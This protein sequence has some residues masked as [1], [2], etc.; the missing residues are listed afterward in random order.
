[1]FKSNASFD[2]NGLLHQ[3]HKTS[4]SIGKFL[5]VPALARGVNHV[6]DRLGRDKAQ[7]SG[8]SS[9][10]ASSQVWSAVLDANDINQK[11]LVRQIGCV[12]AH[13]KASGAPNGDREGLVIEGVLKG[14]FFNVL[15]KAAHDGAARPKTNVKG[16]AAS[17]P[18]AGKDLHEA[19]VG[20]LEGVHEWLPGS[21]TAEGSAAEKDTGLKLFGHVDAAVEGSLLDSVVCT[22]AKED[23]NGIA[24]SRGESKG[25]RVRRVAE[26][27]VGNDAGSLPPKA[28]R[29][30]LADGDF[31]G[32]D[33]AI[34]DGV[35]LGSRLGF[36]DRSR[37]AGVSLTL[38]R[39][40]N[41]SPISLLRRTHG[42]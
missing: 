20:A 12:G 29:K 34:D 16:S 19:Q 17:N 21:S 3:N 5:V 18:G 7:A 22:V 13:K 39:A 6:K 35:L 36:L 8:G 37:H 31:C 33:K 10:D 28:S 11:V 27:G 14:W 30:D 42:R 9:N 1:M 26:L 2:K 4:V 38:G 40:V 23:A 41:L 15:H 25:R 24:E 32:D